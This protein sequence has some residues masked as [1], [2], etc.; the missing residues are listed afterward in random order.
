MDA[1][2]ELGS[3]LYCRWRNVKSLRDGVGP[4]IAWILDLK[5]GPAALRKNAV[6][7]SGRGSRDQMITLPET[8]PLAQWSRRA[9]W[10]QRDE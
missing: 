6:G 7:F 2:R 1:E 4:R 5:T 8:R 9:R 10:R 3:S